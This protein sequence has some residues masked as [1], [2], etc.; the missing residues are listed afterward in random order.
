MVCIINFYQTFTVLA[1]VLLTIYLFICLPDNS[2]VLKVALILVL[3]F[4]TYGLVA[5][6]FP[7]FAPS[8]PFTVAITYICIMIFYAYFSSGIGESFLLLALLVGCLLIPVAA[9][10]NL[11]VWFQEETGMYISTNVVLVLVLLF[12]LLIASLIYWFQHQPIV[13]D[14]CK[15]LFYSVLAL[16]S[17]RLCEILID[18]SNPSEFCCSSDN[19]ST[20]P[21][22][23]SGV[24]LLLLPMLILFR[25]ALMYLWRERKNKIKEQ[26]S[27]TFCGCC[28]CCLYIRG[29]MREQRKKWKEKDE[30]EEQEEKKEQK[31][32]LVIIQSIS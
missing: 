7:G 21:L 27:N 20:C 3:T 18:Q 13:W 5:S 1:A 14:V 25:L 31:Q 16:L 10:D 17:L 8:A 23:F 6:F 11:G 12:I 2:V 29:K 9:R 32:P 26:C 28:C 19:E 4:L 24:Y 15:T 22:F 30:E